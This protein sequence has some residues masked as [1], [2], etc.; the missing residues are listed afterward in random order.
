MDEI[1]ANFIRYGGLLFK[2]VLVHLQNLC[3]QQYIIHNTWKMTL[4]KLMFE[5]GGHGDN[6]NLRIG[7]FITFRMP[8]SRRTEWL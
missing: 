1:T 6:K 3:M 8:T 2:L 7:D 5:K 4:K